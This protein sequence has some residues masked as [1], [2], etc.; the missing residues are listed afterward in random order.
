[1][2]KLFNPHVPNEAINEVSDV[3]NSGCVT[4]GSRVESFEKNFSNLFNVKYPVSLNSG[5]SALELAY[6]LVGLQEGDEVITTPLTCA[7]TNIPLLHKKVKIVWADINPNTLCIDLKDVGKKITDKT[8]AIVQVHLGGIRASLGNYEMDVPVI[9]DACQALGVFSGDYTCCSFQAI[10]HFTTGDGGM[11]VVNNEKEY[12]KSKLLRWFGVDRERKIPN[13]WTS[14]RTRMMSFDIELAG[15]K[16]H[17]NDIDAALGLVGLLHYSEILQYRRKLF[18]MYEKML[19]GVDGIKIV[20]GEEN[21]YWLFTILVERRDDFARM[22]YDAGVETN[23]VQ[24]RNDGYK[25]FGGKKADL[26]NLASIENK[27]ISLPIGMHVKEEEVNYICS[28]I[29]NGW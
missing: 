18:Y 26:P 27:Y 12:K 10:K 29:R 19:S 3:L 6:E 16:K 25:V 11:L 4:Q 9:S 23:L 2:I 15:Y 20:N 22:L 13:D 1:M 8:K 14:Y 7:A 17:M 5:S 21:V 28:K 24:V